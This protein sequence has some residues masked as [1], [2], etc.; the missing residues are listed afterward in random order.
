M[1]NRA[2]RRQAQRQAQ[3]EG[4]RPVPNKI[5]RPTG[6]YGIA[7]EYDKEQ[8]FV[9]FAVNEGPVVCTVRWRKKDALAIADLLKKAATEDDETKDVEVIMESGLIMPPKGIQL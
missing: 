5:D 3:R 8:G 7:I 9:Y 4:K 1:S 6:E 2:Q